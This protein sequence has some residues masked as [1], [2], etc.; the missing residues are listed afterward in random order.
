MRMLLCEKSFRDLLRSGI[1][2]T[3]QKGLDQQG[4]LAEVPA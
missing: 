3:Q 4:C 2:F 1:V